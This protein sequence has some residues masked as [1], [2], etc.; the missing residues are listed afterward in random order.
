[1]PRQRFYHL[2][3][4][5][6]RRL[7]DIA[8]RHFATEGFERASLNEILAEAGISKG[9]YYYYFDDKDDLFATALESAVDDLMARLPLPALEKLQ[10]AEFWPTVERFVAS[11]AS[12]LDV[13]SDLFQAALQLTESQRQSPRFAQMLEKSATVYRALIA[14]G[15]RLGCIRSDIS[16]DALVRLLQ[17]SDAVL[18][19]IFVSTHKKVT[20]ASMAAHARLVFDTFKRLLVAEPFA[21]PKAAKPRGKRRG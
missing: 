8:T 7:V 19:A 15:R 4:Q 16:V 3:P 6:R 13:S 1:M 10:A 17:A 21:A 12:S 18:D 5:E 2:A 14:P 11:W 9:S 20:R